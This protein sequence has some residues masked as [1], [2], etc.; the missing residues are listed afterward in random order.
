MRAEGLLPSHVYNW[1]DLPETPRPYGASK[2]FFSGPTPNLGHFSVSVTRLNPGQ[3]PHPPHEHAEEEVILIKEGTA[4]ITMAGK[5]YDA[6]AGTVTY[7]APNTHHGIVA[8][9]GPV[10]YFVIRWGGK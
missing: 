4:K 1:N 2:P 7:Y 6:P 3:A 9:S 10:T 5:T 8:G